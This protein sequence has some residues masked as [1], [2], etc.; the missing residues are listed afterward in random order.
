[1]IKIVKEWKYNLANRCLIMDN[2]EHQVTYDSLQLCENSN[3]TTYF[4][5]YDVVGERYARMTPVE[6]FFSF[7]EENENCMIR[8]TNCCMFTKFKKINGYI[9]FYISDVPK[10]VCEYETAKEL[11]EE[12]YNYTI[13]QRKNNIY[14]IPTSGNDIKYID[15]FEFKIIYDDVEEIL[16]LFPHFVYEP[17]K[18]DI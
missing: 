2:Y 12:F 7:L 10:F 11:L 15:D 9:I 1:M 6:Q 3:D 16:K 17:E 18:I 14:G 8:F 5:I 13:Y 4:I